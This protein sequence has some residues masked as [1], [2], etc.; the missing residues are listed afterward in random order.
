MQLERMIIQ[1]LLQ[2]V[3]KTFQLD[4]APAFISTNDRWRLAERI[5]KQTDGPP[6]LQTPLVFLRLTQLQLNT[7]NFNLQAL[8]AGQY[9]SLR[10]G[11]SVAT[12]YVILP[13]IYTFEVTHLCLDFWEQLSFA[14]RFI[15]S[16]RSRGILSFMLDYD[17]IGLDVR[18]M[19]DSSVSTPEK[20]V[21]VDVAGLY[22]TVTNL[23][24]S[25]YVSFDL[26]EATQVP[27]ITSTSVTL[28]D[29]AGNPL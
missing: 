29:G 13:A 28:R 4:Q 24:V 6:A 18:V 10:Q 7:D 21:S 1:G 16:Q 20:D 17:G 26:D 11:E 25:G 15:L 19:C 23:T 12:K 27:V 22:E 8:V 3:Q 14:R 2:K 5:N 9:G